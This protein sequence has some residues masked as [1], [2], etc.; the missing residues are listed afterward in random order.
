MVDRNQQ[1]NAA[2]HRRTQELAGLYEISKILSEV[3]EFV[4]KAT[5][6]M[7]KVA[8]LADADWVTLR[9][10]NDKEPG[11]HLIAAAG[12]A[13]AESPPISVFTAT[14]TTSTQVFS[15]GS[16]VVIDDYVDQP[17]AAQQLVGM[18]MRSMVVLPVKTSDRTLGIVTVI[19]KKTGHF[20]PELVQLLTEVS[21]GLGVLLENSL[22]HERSEFA[23][24]AQRRMAEESSVLAEIGRI[25][26]S[27]TDIKEVYETFGEKIRSLVPFD[28]MSLSFANYENETMSPTWVVGTDVP[29]LREGDDFPM[30]NSLAGQVV[31]T[32]EPYLLEADTEPDLENR[33]PGLMPIYRAGTNSF[34]A[35]PLL[36][37]DVVIGVLRVGS[38]HKGIYTQQHLELLQRMG[39]QIAGAV[40]NAQLYAEKMRAD[41]EILDL[42]RF[43]SENPNP[44]VRISADGTIMYAND[45]ADRILA[46]RGLKVGDT[47]LEDW[48]RWVKEVLATDT[49]KEVEIVY[50]TRFMSYSLAPVQEAGYVNI[51]GRD[52]TKAKEIERL[53]DDLIS[54]VSHELRT[55][56][57]S[58]KGAVEILLTYQDEDPAMQAE[59]LG[60]ID[61][62]SDRLA[63]LIENVLDIARFQSGQMQFRLSEVEV[64][65]VIDAAIRS[66]HSLTIQKDLKVAILLKDDL[67]KVFSDQDRLVQVVTN[68]LSNAIKFTPNGGS[69]QVQSPISNGGSD[70]AMVEISVSGNGVGI[71]ESELSN[72]FNRFQ[73]AGDTLSSRPQGSGLGLHISREI[74]EHL[75]GKIWVESKPG[76]GST[77]FFTVPVEEASG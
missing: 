37:R 15:E 22:L 46:D 39:D 51:Y 23:Y 75:G 35:V 6:A 48:Q 14:M 38:K 47:T 36:S 3:G 11:L 62:E 17:G 60:I 76:S 13:V 9:M 66:T 61:K 27:S 57:T 19:S 72:I 8:A 65:E 20:S 52:I 71:D 32:K 63:R 77:F 2:E 58:I 42:A 43:P 50:G 31:R 4:P 59:F 54:N 64:P 70:S 68:L 28:R 25:V 10:P 30:E 45:A 40:A 49:P 21:E 34:M 26:S 33:F 73:Q 16:V 12:P 7:E 56:L 1:A 29:G 41:Q 53:K 18:G 74:V 5:A 24:Q 55:P 69:I 67:P 44:V